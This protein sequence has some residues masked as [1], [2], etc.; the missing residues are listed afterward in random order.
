MQVK[1]IV[2]GGD[3]RPSEIDLELPA[4]LGRGRDARISLPQGLVSRRHCE[5]FESEGMLRVRDLGSLNGTFVGS[6]R[7]EDAELPAGDLLTVGTVT[8]RAV[9]GE[10]MT[11][12]SSS[13][14]EFVAVTPVVSDERDSVFSDEE[15]SA[16][17][18]TL[19]D[20]E[21][22][23]TRLGETLIQPKNP[24]P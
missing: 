22:R 23:A 18:S 14:G 10:K 21:A 8:F 5:L 19:E 20:D 3:V 1:L 15:Y 13:S 24:N 12:S 17:D 9:Y 6:Q 4:V 11:L 2:V 7:I 16:N